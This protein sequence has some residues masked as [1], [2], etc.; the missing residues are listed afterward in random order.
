MLA[1]ASSN[2]AI[3]TA[4]IEDPGTQST[5]YQGRGHMQSARGMFVA[6]WGM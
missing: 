5:V 2:Q 3:G 1:L 6:K 4:I